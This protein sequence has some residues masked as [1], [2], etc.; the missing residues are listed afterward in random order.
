MVRAG[1]DAGQ[2]GAAGAGAP[3]R[4]G[5]RRPRRAPL[6]RGASEEASR[7]DAAREAELR[8]RVRERAWR[9][10]GSG[11]YADP[12]SLAEFQAR[13]AGAGSAGP[14]RH[15]R[16]GRR[17][18]RHRSG[19][20]TTH[21]LGLARRPRVPARWAVARARH[22]GRAAARDLRAVGARRGEQPVC[23]RSTTSCWRRWP[24]GSATCRWCSRRRGRW[25]RCRGR[26]LPSN[27]GRPLVVAES[28]TSWAVRSETPLRSGTAGFVAGPRV[29]QAESETSVRVAGVARAPGCCTGARRRPRRSAG[30]PVEVD[31]LH[32]SA[33]GRHSSENPLFSGF[34]LAGRAVVRLR[35]RPARPACRTSY[36]SRRARSGARRCAAARS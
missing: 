3:R 32:V 30:W 5:G 9:L 10:R 21:D 29:A 2:P 23:A 20:A 25:P 26:S 34:E 19:R 35:H 6:A 17:A 1:A 27:R 14:C 7:E 12:M 13:L 18:G 36:C 24:T 8:Q 22:G 11:A 16:P 33:H 31:V 4:A 15:R 28:A